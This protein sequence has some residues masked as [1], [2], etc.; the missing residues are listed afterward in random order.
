MSEIC[1]GLKQLITTI[2][3]KY[4]TSTDSLNYLEDV[5]IKSKCKKIEI[6][7]FKYPVGG[8]CLH[9][10]LL[11]NK[12]IFTEDYVE[13]LFCLFHELTHIYQ[14]N[15]YGAEKM[16]GLLD[17]NTDVNKLANWL[18]SIELTADEMGKRQLQKMIRLGLIKTDKVSILG[19][20]KLVPEYHF[21]KIVDENR[22]ILSDLTIRDCESISDLYR[23]TVL[24]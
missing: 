14:F 4:N 2:K 16:Y 19:R 18:K 7:N 22:K 1:I 21:L 15:K 23:K 8:M 24:I 9:D 10:S 3:D 5:V 12:S 11:L 20:Y 17:I 6:V 13:M